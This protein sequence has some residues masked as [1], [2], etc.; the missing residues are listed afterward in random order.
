MN[1]L[2]HALRGL[3][4]G[5]V[6]EMDIAVRRG[7]PAMPEQP[8]R[9]KRLAVSN[10]EPSAKP[11]ISTEQVSGLLFPRGSEQKAFP[12]KG[13]SIVASPRVGRASHVPRIADAVDFRINNGHRCQK[14]VVLQW[15]IR[16]LRATSSSPSLRTQFMLRTRNNRD[17]HKVTVSI[18]L[19]AGPRL[20]EFYDATCLTDTAAA[21]TPPAGRIPG[22][23]PAGSPSRSPPPRR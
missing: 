5:R 11:S 9:D 8:S 21:V 3:A 17:R 18:R 12:M 6:I 13:K 15:V 20:D 2:C 16:H 19:S 4:Q 1:R 10:T 23:A 7:R 14:T 22:S